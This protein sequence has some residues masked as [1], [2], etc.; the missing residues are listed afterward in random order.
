MAKKVCWIVI[1]L[2]IAINV[3]MLHFTIESY[4]GLEFEHV[5]I[6]TVI[7]LISALVALITYMYWRKLEYSETKK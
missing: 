6:N 4:F 3:V 5:Y 2:T 7:A 1:F